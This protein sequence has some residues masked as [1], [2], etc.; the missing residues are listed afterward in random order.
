[1]NQ[2]LFKLSYSQFDSINKAQNACLAIMDGETALGEVDKI[3][4]L[5]LDC[6]EQYILHQF[7]GDFFFFNLR[8][9]DASGALT[10]AWCSNSLKDKGLTIFQN[11]VKAFQNTQICERCFHLKTPVTPVPSKLLHSVYPHSQSK[12]TW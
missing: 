3:E 1:M 12:L 4:V 11:Y 8:L 9:D 5:L 6:P 10:P 7:S 2:L